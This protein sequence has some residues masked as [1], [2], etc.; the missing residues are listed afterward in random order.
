[1]ADNGTLKS[2]HSLSV[3]TPQHLAAITHPTFPTADAIGQATGRSH[4]GKLITETTLDLPRS[5][6]AT[7]TA[8][9]ATALPKPQDEGGTRQIVLRITSG[10]QPDTGYKTAAATGQVGEGTGSN[11]Y[12]LAELFLTRVTRHAVIC[13]ERDGCC[14]V[15][16][17][18]SSVTNCLLCGDGVSHVGIS[19]TIADG[20]TCGPSS[21]VIPRVSRETRNRRRLSDRNLSHSTGHPEGGNTGRGYHIGERGKVFDTLA[22]AWNPGRC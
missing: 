16:V 12:L 4:R 15:P 20:W 19:D 8:N 11:K 22:I 6:S 18:P 5:A 17:R 14:P 1:M 2:T 7:H 9:A 10:A 3:F 21:G 13:E